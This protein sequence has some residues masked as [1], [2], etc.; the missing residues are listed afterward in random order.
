MNS[1]VRWILQGR[2]IDLFQKTQKHIVYSNYKVLG[3]CT[4]REDS[5]IHIFIERCLWVLTKSLKKKLFRRTQEHLLVIFHCFVILSHQ[6][7]PICFVFTIATLFFVILP[8]ANRSPLIVHVEGDGSRIWYFHS[9]CGIFVLPQRAVF[10]IGISLAEFLT[11][12][13]V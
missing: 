12:Y 2:V 4:Y 5:F 7:Q 8:I 11:W 13:H 1:Y 3:R 9:W 10:I 6:Q